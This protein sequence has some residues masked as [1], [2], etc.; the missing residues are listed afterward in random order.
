VRHEVTAGSV[1]MPTGPAITGFCELMD[2]APWNASIKDADGRYLYLNRHYRATLGNR[3]GPAWYGKPDSEIWDAEVAARRR[4]IDE[5][6]ISGTALPIFQMVVPYPDGRHTHLLMKFPLPTDD[7]R[8]VVAGVGLDVTAHARSEAEHDRLSAA[9]EQATETVEITDLEAR[10]TYVNPAFERTTGYSRDEVLGQ[11]PRILSSG[12]QPPAYYEAMWSM[13]TSGRPWSADMVNRR[14]DGSLFTEAATISPIRDA[15]GETTG[16]VAVK[17]DVTSERAHENR[18]ASLTRQRLLIAA[19]IRDLRAGDTPEATAEAICRQVVNLPDVVK[20]QI[21]LFELDGTARPIGVHIPGHHDPP[22]RS[23]PARRSRQ[24]RKRAA[25]GPWIEAWINRPRHPYNR[26]LNSL[27]VH[28]VAYAP[29]RD[30]HGLIGVLIVDSP[31]SVGEGALVEILPAIVEFADLTGSHIGA[32]VAERTEVLRIRGQIRTVIDHRAF[33]PVFQP[34]VDL[35]HGGVVGFEA[36]TRFADG[37]APQVRFRDAEDAGLGLQLE[38]ATL[39]AALVAAD[40]LP[41]HAWLD[42]NV[43][44]GLVFERVALRELLRRHPGRRLVIEVTE[45]QEVADYPAFRAAI[46]AVD[47]TLEVAVDD[48]GAGFASL[49]HILELRPAFVKL[50]RWLVS[51]IDAD[52]ARQAMIAGVLHFASSTG[53]RIIAEGIEAPAERD[54]LRALGVH[55][56]QGYLLGRPVPAP[57]ASAASRDV[58]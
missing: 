26:L 35:E 1:A 12:V 24:L 56:G 11:N 29:I 6:T 30:D 17:R 39:E 22:V 2:A 41:P 7:G 4:E 20:A 33:Q 15:A 38:A 43:S 28:S 48:A 23:L 18:S 9:I 19:T 57:R 13:L 53:C 42:I 31:T 45:H 37:V 34:I 10:I 3:F 54:T 32:H 55:L 16:Y 44:P 51:A 50:D 40:T 49:R 21:F 25:E 52:E 58:P 27:N 5:A 36:L 47:P 46:A 8:V 14:K